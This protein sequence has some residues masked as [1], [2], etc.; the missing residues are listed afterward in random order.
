MT[1]GGADRCGQPIRS[2]GLLSIVSNRKVWEKVSASQRTTTDRHQSALTSGR[3]VDVG[4]TKAV[5]SYGGDAGEKLE[6]C[7]RCLRQ[8]S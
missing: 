8:G 5:H 2:E 6:T 4:Q 3:T 7:D 1:D